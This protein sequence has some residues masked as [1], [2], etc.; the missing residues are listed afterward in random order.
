MSLS[1]IL[2]TEQYYAAFAFPLDH[3]LLSS[4][5]FA[6]FMVQAIAFSMREPTYSVRLHALWIVI[7]STSYAFSKGWVSAC[8]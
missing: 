1:H 6:I 3:L 8:F 4:F 2:G 5:A 7:F